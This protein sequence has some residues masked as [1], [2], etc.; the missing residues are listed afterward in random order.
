MS[1]FRARLALL[2]LLGLAVRLVAAR[3]NRDWPVIGDALTYHL[4]AGYL[5]G[6]EG[7]RRA[8]EDLPTA[9]HPPAHIVVLALADLLGI[10]GTANQKAYMGVVG[11]VTVALTGLL[12]RRVA[13]PRAGL[14]AAGLA[15]VYP[16]LFLPD[17]ALMSETT[18]TLL[19]VVVAL[20]AFG[21]ADR[22]SI[23]AAALLGACIA[24]AALARGEALG[25]LVLLAAPLAWRAGAGDRRR[26]AVLG[27][28]CVAAFAVVLAP[29]SVRNLTTFE[30]PV[31]LSTNG[32]AVWVGANCPRTYF[33]ELTGAWVFSCFGTKAPPGDEAEQAVVY[34]ERGLTYAREHA[35]RIPA[36]VLARLGRLLDVYRPWD[37][38]VFFAATEG[39]KPTLQR[40]G[41]IAYWGLLPFAVAGLVVLRRRGRI[42]A[43]LVLL[44]PIALVVLVGAVVYGSTRFRTA[45]EP[46]IVVAA[47]V[48]L[49][50]LLG[51][52]T[53]RRRAAPA[54]A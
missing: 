15:A 45:A 33:G 27:A 36:V 48:A 54:A 24:L 1:S 16:M 37:Q 52:L 51:R 23:R 13:G 9:E 40:L 47:A 31:L 18:S 42:D 26:A 22:R 21:L 7:F 41:L 34:R 38:G 53:R 4:E 32:D 14:V 44:A 25:L 20:A 29:W 19:V 6:G 49:D 12:G 28:T 43:V 50:A 35:D 10:D 17:A 30:R 11:T 5:A 8:F 39:R 2:T 3:V 46:M